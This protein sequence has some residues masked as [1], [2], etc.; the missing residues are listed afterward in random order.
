[1]IFVFSLWNILSVVDT[2]VYSKV[3]C[4][5]KLIEAQ[6]S[7]QNWLLLMKIKVEVLCRSLTYICCG[8]NV[9]T[10]TLVNL[11]IWLKQ[12]LIIYVFFWGRVFMQPRLASDL[13]YNWGLIFLPLPRK[14]CA[15]LFSS[16]SS[17]IPF[18]TLMLYAS[19]EILLMR[20]SK[21][22]FWSLSYFV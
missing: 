11:K 13:L 22:V 5:H 9:G 3:G 18:Y 6:I 21:L 7:S 14:W 8:R 17:Q 1:M 16:S 10:S 19:I 2:N 15:I 20:E 12:Q 4:A